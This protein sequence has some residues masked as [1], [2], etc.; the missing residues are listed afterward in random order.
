MQKF[1]A[2]YGLATHLAILVAAPIFLYQTMPNALAS[3]MLGILTVFA[4][5]W[6][7]M[8]PSLRSGEALN[9]ARVRVFKSLRRDP[10][11]WGMLVIALVAGVRALNGGI[12]IGYDAESLMWSVQDQFFPLLPGCVDGFGSQ[13]FVT[14]LALTVALQAV[15]HALGR[16]ARM[17]FCLI[18]SSISGVVAMSSLFI[19]HEG[20]A[21]II[22]SMKCS[23]AWPSYL[24]V[25]YGIQLLL[26]TAATVTA[27]ERS[28]NSALL[29]FLIAIGGNAAGLFAFAPSMG[30]VA[31]TAAEVLLFV[32]AMLYSFKV[33]SHGG[34]FKLLILVLS[35]LVVGGVASVGM[36]PSAI[37]DSKLTLILS[38][39]IFPKNYFEMWSMSSAISFKTWLS[40]P[41]VGVGLGAFPLQLRFHIDPTQWAALPQG[42]RLPLSLWWGIIAERGIIGALM[43]LLPI[44]FLLFAY[45]RALSRI[46]R[47]W[48]FLHPACCLGP[49]GLLA[50]LFVS[51]FDCSLLRADVLIAA[52]VML[53]ISSAAF[54]KERRR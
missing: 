14:I 50:I 27:F 38:G 24:G 29:F 35:S 39:E 32:A 10:L 33:F 30:I 21:E 1:I 37:I 49:F 53:A 3:F 54:P 11:F 4:L 15:R 34:E 20:N 48:I 46:R 8:E 17:A 18:S 36:L 13:S 52:G 43:F 51:F 47:F 31:F 44:G 28:W 7:L 41:W 40:A 9:A 2:K 22:E 16:S 25:G 23:L 12:S 6:M 5:I 42:L 19:A 45:G 26:G